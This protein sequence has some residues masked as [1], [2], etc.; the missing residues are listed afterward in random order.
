MRI[1]KRNALLIILW[2]VCYSHTQAQQLGEFSP[3]DKTTGMNKLHSKKMYIANFT[4]NYQVFNEKE[5]TK[6]GGML[7]GAKG[8][9]GNAK[10]ELTVGLG[11]LSQKDLQQLTDEIYTEFKDA[12]T[13]KGF[14]LLSS[15]MAGKTEVYKNYER[16]ENADP[17]LAEQPG[18]I[19]IYP[20]NMVFYIKGL[21]N[22]G[23]VKKGGFMGS[24]TRNRGSSSLF[25]VMNIFPKL[26]SQ[27]EDAIIANVDLYVFFIE[28]LN[29]YKGDAANIRI[30]TSLRLISSDYVT[31]KTADK[32]IFAKKADQYAT[33]T[34]QID[35]V[36]GRYNIGGSAETVYTGNMKKDLAIEGVIDDRVIKSY[37]KG[38]ADFVGTDTYFGTLYKGENK[39]STVVSEVSVNVE[40][41]KKGVKAAAE[42]FLEHHIDNFSKSVK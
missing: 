18:L 38:G 4:V 20:S 34:S 16:L 23:K 35:F 33:G 13:A 17:S 42:K 40:T 29:A 8:V 3:K 11:N 27:L 10:A 24:V 9:R 1:M 41:Y 37:A 32:S 31:S 22:D 28:D 21:T 39:S 26:S 6:K 14:E 15:D 36:S 5:E 12:I 19:T 2:M 25:E 7:I 30:K